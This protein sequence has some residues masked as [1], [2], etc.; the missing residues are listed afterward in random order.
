MILVYSSSYLLVIWIPYFKIAKISRRRPLRTWL[1]IR[2]SL[3][4]MTIDFQGQTSPHARIAPLLPMIMSYSST[5]LLVIWI[6]NFKNAKICCVLPLRPTRCKQLD[7]NAM[8]TH[9]QGK[10]LRSAQTLNFF[11]DRV[12]WLTIFIVDPYIP[13]SKMQTFLMDVFLQLGCAFGLISMPC[14]LNFKVKRALKSG[15]HPLCQ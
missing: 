12:L 4:F 7:L 1:C 15:S 2:L 14:P 13:T 9:F 8:T 6:S 11:Y 3:K 5:S 10:N